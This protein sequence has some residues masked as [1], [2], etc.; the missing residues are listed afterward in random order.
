MRKLL[1]PL[2]LGTALSLM[3]DATLY[4]V[5]PTHTAEAGIA[6]GGVG[7]LL[8]VNRAVRLF[9]NGPVGLAYD[10]IP[11]RRLFVPALFV[12]ALSTA[13]YAAT[14]GFWPLFVGRLL[15]GLAWSGI[16]VGGATMI[17]EA[18]ALPERG[19][20]TGL[21]QTWF[22]VGT[23]LGALG[24]GVLTDL[25]GYT[26]TMWICA[27][28][29][30]AGGLVALVLLPE[31]SA[32]T[33][34]ETSSA[35]AP[36]AA[37]P[38]SGPQPP[39][40][41]LGPGRASG[42]GRRANRE[43]WLAVSLQGV[44]RFIISGVLSGTLGL[45][46]Q[47]WVGAS[48]IAIGVATLTGVV[49]AGRTVLSMG[50]A[51]LAGTLSDRSGSRWTVVAW[52]LAIGAGGMVLLSLDGPVGIVAGISAVAISG[53]SLQALATT[54]T[55]DAAGHAQRGRA[56]G[57]LHTAGD[58]GSAIGPSIAYA[59]LPLIGLRTMY[60][61]CAGLFLISLGPILRFYGK[62]QGHLRAPLVSRG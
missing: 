15:W 56:I 57:M 26:A 24:G 45:L 44:N 25:L 2:G 47:D 41:D 1:F 42:Q 37:D 10:R 13:L 20:W 40:P 22:F 38:G 30:A 19:R 17:L 58:F 59:L 55:G 9:L 35:R 8:G 36:A 51:P 3:G 14:Q 6:L 54:L 18:A 28:L 27:A 5:L 21:Y 33:S 34:T 61:L 62:Q 48:G 53:G 31:T 43:L 39:I 23:T 60:L 11:R 46:I 7:I 29:T 16:W 12:G 52:S 32:E 4:T 49:M 50:A